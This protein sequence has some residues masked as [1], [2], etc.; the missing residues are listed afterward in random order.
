MGCKKG[1]KLIAY[2]SDLIQYCKHLDGNKN[3]CPLEADEKVKTEID[4]LS[5]IEMARL[6]RFAEP[7]HPYFSGDYYDYFQKR[8]K[9]LGGMTPEISKQL[10]W[11]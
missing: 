8:F 11:S 1:C 7:G 9:E 5:Q 6:I 2:D 10:G 3:G 4:F